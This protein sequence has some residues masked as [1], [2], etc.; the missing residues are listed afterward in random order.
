MKHIINILIGMGS[1]MNPLGTRPEYSYPKVGDRNRDF[2]RLAGDWNV[3]GTHLRINTKEALSRNVK[4]AYYRQG[5]A[6]R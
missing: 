5:E 6:S 4:L 2:E 3:V 1:V